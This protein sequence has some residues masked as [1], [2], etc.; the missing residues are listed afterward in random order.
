M[1]AFRTLEKDLK[2]DKYLLRCE[3]ELQ[4]PEDLLEHRQ[5]LPIASHRQ[6][7]LD[8]ISKHDIILIKGDT[9][10]GKSTQ[11]PQ[12][13]LEDGIGRGQG[14]MTN[15]L[16]TQ[17]RR[18]SAISLAERVR[19]ERGEQREKFREDSSVGYEVRFDAERPRAYG[20]IT[21]CTTG[22]AL[23]RL[24]TNPELKDISHV[25]IDEVHERDIYTDVLLGILFKLHKTS[26]KVIVMSASMNIGAFKKYLKCP[27]VEVQGRLFPI[28]EY[29]LEDFI[30]GNEVEIPPKFQPLNFE[31]SKYIRRYGKHLGRQICFL[32]NASPMH[33]AF[34][35]QCIKMIHDQGNP[36]SI[37]VFLPG[38]EE[39]SE[40]HHLLSNLEST[41]TYILTTFF[42][43]KNI[44]SFLT[45]LDGRPNHLCL[46]NAEIHLLHSSSSLE[47]QLKIF[48]PPSENMRKIVLSTNLA[49]TSVTIEDIVY[50]IDCGRVNNVRYNEY[51][52]STALKSEWISKS[53]MIQ[54]SGRAG[55]V[56]AGKCWHLLS[57]K[58]AE[59]LPLNLDPSIKRLPLI[60]TVLIIKS[61]KLNVSTDE[62][63][64]TLIDRPHDSKVEDAIDE[65]KEIGAIDIL[66]EEL[67]PLGQ[68][69]ALLPCHPRLGKMVLMACMFK[70]LVPILDIVAVLS[71]KDPFILSSLYD[72]SK[73]KQE[74][75]MTR[76]AFDNG[77]HSD[78]LMFHSLYQAWENTYEAGISW[79]F[80]A[81]NHLNE[82][83]LITMWK[84]K[85]DVY[86]RLVN[87]ALIKDLQDANI[88]ARNPNLI[89]G[90]ICSAFH[91]AKC[92]RNAS[93]DF[94]FVLDEERR[95][96]IWID[97]KSVNQK[98]RMPQKYMAYFNL[99]VNR[100][101]NAH[102][103]DC[104][105]VHEK[106]VDVFAN[107]ITDNECFL[108]L[109]LQICFEDFCL[110]GYF[111]ESKTV[112][113]VI[114]FIKEN[115]E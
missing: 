55:R 13:I 96:R 36:G 65:L 108:S 114:Q 5:D 75:E 71:D 113:D 91:I 79:E 40:V 82:K 62:F 51:H 105:N 84:I 12:F 25:I 70:C 58:K 80:C 48:Y 83:V 49:E 73:V 102:I 61:L 92:D 77:L 110:G 17:P 112:Q 27:V 52:K 16:V 29:Y 97:W 31:L 53:S 106:L 115:V 35:A 111:I 72:R 95:E 57:R 24:K 9:G 34:I 66:T 22:V 45:F 88:N 32:E 10:S 85:K 78:H 81:K 33:Y 28:E 3:E 90:I 8:L 44:F 89:R 68:K 93:K 60:D 64:N 42:S 100:K 19:N 76:Q 1:D 30:V 99:Q 94:N 109:L 87:L 56:Q 43:Q 50:V 86:S 7:I 6:E 46:K 98:I 41:G 15:V 104:T 2:L 4:V 18:I 23:Q 47:E 26:I 74:T 21:Y 20:A 67:T 14:S 59:S 11:V 69:L 38:W 63:L 54:R 101:G 107:H 37:L 103:K 39:I